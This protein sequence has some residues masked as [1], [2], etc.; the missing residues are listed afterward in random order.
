MKIR[1]SGFYAGI[2]LCS[3]VRVSY[4]DYIIALGHPRTLRSGGRVVEISFS[5]P[6]VPLSFASFFPPPFLLE[7]IF[8]DGNGAI[9]VGRRS[10]L[11]LLA[12]VNRNYLINHAGE[13]IRAKGYARAAFHA[14][15]S[16]CLLAPLFTSLLLVTLFYLRNTNIPSCFIYLLGTLHMCQYDSQA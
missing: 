1:Y 9:S 2:S 11:P 13:D 3:N 5:H 16:S 14:R 15:V 12:L 8:L 10:L 7:K 4:S 6:H